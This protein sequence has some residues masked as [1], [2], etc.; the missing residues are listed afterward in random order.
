MLA[1][2][3]ALRATRAADVAET[4]AILA[5]LSPLVDAAGTQTP[6]N[7]ENRDA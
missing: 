6:P 2:L 1:E 5:A 7:K 3:E 4:S